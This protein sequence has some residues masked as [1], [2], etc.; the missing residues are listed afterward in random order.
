MAVQFMKHHKAG[1]LRRE[2]LEESEM[3]DAGHKDTRCFNGQQKSK[4]STF[5]WEQ[6]E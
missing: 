5:C 2:N 1:G 4:E 6:L 3:E